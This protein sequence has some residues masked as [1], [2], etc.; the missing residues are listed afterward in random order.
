VVPKEAPD[1]KGEVVEV[2]LE[3]MLDV[4]EKFIH[5]ES[6][7]GPVINVES[8][9]AASNARGNPNITPPNLIFTDA[10][11]PVAI[12]EMSKPTTIKYRIPLRRSNRSVITD[13]P[14]KYD[15]ACQFH[16]RLW[17]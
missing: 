7:G 2:P 1:A 11:M 16:I 8:A 13:T 14:R 15:V 12:N 9:K 17:I 10:Y 6:L 4:E 3:F 5:W